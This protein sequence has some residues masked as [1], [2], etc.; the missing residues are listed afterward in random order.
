MPNK[1]MIDPR[2]YVLDF[3]YM[4]DGNLENKTS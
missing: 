3:R 1:H 4:Q 2:S